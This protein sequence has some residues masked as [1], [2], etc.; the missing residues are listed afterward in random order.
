[1][2]VCD[3][4]LWSVKLSQN[5]SPDQ[6][7]KGWIHRDIVLS[8]KIDPCLRNFLSN[9]RLAAEATKHGHKGVSKAGSQRVG[10][11]L[12]L[13]ERFVTSGLGLLWKTPEPQYPG[14]PKKAR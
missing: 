5:P 1:M 3:P 11:L 13:V 12:G 9:H 2:H 10:Q 14:Q 7:C 4:V 8:A 6:S